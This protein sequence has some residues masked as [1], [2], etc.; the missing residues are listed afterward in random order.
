M[1]GSRFDQLARAMGGQRT[2]RGFL[3]GLA[4]LVAGAAGLRAADDA[5]AVCPPGSVAASGGRCI[6]KSNGRQPGPTGCPCPA[7]QTSCDGGITC[8]DLSTDVANCGACG[9]RCP[10]PANA[11]ASCVGGSCT[12]AC[13]AGYVSCGGACIPVGGCC[14][15]GVAVA[16]GTIDPSNACQACQPAVTTTAWSDRPNGTTCDDGNRCTR[17]D[18]CQ[19]G[20]CV[21]GNPVVCTALDQCH[22]AGTCDPATGACSNPNAPDGTTCSDG[23]ACTADDRCTAGVCLGTAVTCPSPTVCQVSVVCDA[24]S[25][26]CVAVNKPDG[27]LCGADNACSHDVCRAGVCVANVPT[28]KGTACNDANS[29]TQTDACDGAGACV[30]GDP[31]SCPAG[32]TCHGASVC[33]QASGQCGARPLLS[34]SCFIGGV[35]YSAGSDDP[36]NG[37]RVCDPSRSQTAFSAKADGASCDDGNACTR[38]DTCQAGVCVG[39]NPVVCAAKDQCHTAGTCDPATGTCSNPDKPNGTSCDD[40]NATTCSDTCQSGVCRGITCAPATFVAVGTYTYTVPT[41]ITRV[42]IEA[43]G[44]QG[45]SAYPF[46]SGSGGLGGRAAGTVAVTPGQVLQVNVGGAGENGPLT[47]AGS[48]GGFNGGGASGTNASPS[49]G[50]GGGASDVRIGTYA[51]SERIVVGGGGG[52]QGTRNSGSGGAGGGE[53]GT[54]GAAPG[55]DGGTA[56]AGGAGNGGA[57]AGGFG[58]GGAGVTSTSKFLFSGA[59]GGGGWWGGGGGGA[60]DTKGGG[61]GGGSGFVIGTATD[62]AFETGVQS[63]NGSVTITP[64]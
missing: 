45:G 33:D 4:V 41:G 59:G 1:D 14:I 26:S 61:G 34:G 28:L 53:S 22:A 62:R 19:G 5:G 58:N 16:A 12:T 6:C 15:G 13:I 54:A 38:T 24:T 10:A 20:V 25:G 47:S 40:G 39:G 51:L 31:V 11:T 50:G 56:A 29:C 35:C 30:G 36:T 64:L 46:T 63:G 17:T 37:C 60:T 55:G 18:T 43:S 49:P 48:A 32:D 27:T 2:R 23:D 21:G 7:G 9:N 52:G 44:A 42:R 57:A 8:K 3:G